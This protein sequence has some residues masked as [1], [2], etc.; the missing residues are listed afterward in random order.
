M[1]S[2]YAKRTT[3]SVSK[4]VDE[5]KKLVRI[6]GGSNFAYVESEEMAAIA[7][8][9]S[10]RSIKFK[11]DFRSQNDRRYTHTESKGKERTQKA[12]YELWELDCRQKWRVL[13]LLVKATF[14][15]VYTDL[16]DFDAAFMSAIV[17]NSGKTIAEQI[18]P[19]LEKVI[20]TGK[21]PLMI[22]DGGG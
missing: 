21:M 10:N 12:A 11:L 14:E 13:V 17:T 5:L 3:V 20:S 18:L 19:Q 1:S 16:M 22:T 15:A 9:I 6:Y 8:K 2:R 4:S 7:F